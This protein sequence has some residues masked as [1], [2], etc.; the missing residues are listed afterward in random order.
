MKAARFALAVARPRAFC[1]DKVLDA[2]RGAFEAH[3]YEATSVQ[4]LVDA[5]G[6]SRSSLYA[7]FGDKHRLYLAALDRYGQDRGAERACA[8]ADAATPLDGIRLYLDAV[9]AGR[10]CFAVA[11]AAERAGTDPD[12]AARAVQ[13]WTASVAT[14]ADALRRAQ[15]TG[16]LPAHRDADALGATLAATVYGLRGMQSAG[17]DAEACRTVAR[18]AFEALV[19]AGRGA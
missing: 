1:P 9:A 19:D 15:A 3:G 7:A 14:F 11:A 8:F 18:T 13:G 12:T 4:N 17:A 10:G 2:A 16:H 5:T 6:L